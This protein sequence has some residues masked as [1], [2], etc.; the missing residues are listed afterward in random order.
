MIYGQNASRH[1]FSETGRQVNGSVF[2]T[3][4]VET[5]FASHHRNTRFDLRPGSMG[6]HV[7]LKNIIAYRAAVGRW[8][9]MGQLA[10]SR[11][12]QSFL[13]KNWRT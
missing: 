8:M 9:S 1:I 13:G 3:V 6:S 12:G 7:K 5:G 10:E 4:A 11:M 2:G